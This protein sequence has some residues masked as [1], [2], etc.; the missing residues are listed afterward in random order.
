MISSLDRKFRQLV[1][2]IVQ[3]CPEEPIFAQLGKLVWAIS[4]EDSENQPPEINQKIKPEI[5]DHPL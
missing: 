5:T 4:L 1:G 2:A 3:A